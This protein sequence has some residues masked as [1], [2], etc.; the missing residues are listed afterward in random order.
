QDDRRQQAENQAKERAAEHEK[1]VAEFQQ[2]QSALEEDRK[3]LSQK[4]ALLQDDLNKLRAAKQEQAEEIKQMEAAVASQGNALA[5]Q[6][7]KLRQLVAE[8]QSL[9]AQINTMR[10]SEQDLLKRV[11][12]ADNDCHSLKQHIE[13]LSAKAT[14][15]AEEE[16]QLRMRLVNFEAAEEDQR[17]EEH[18]SELQSRSDLVCRLLLE[19][20]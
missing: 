13:A 17:S 10:Q 15:Y 1:R 9:I 3:Q 7:A 11:A 4:E 18:T 14:A 6:A 19:K 20:K 12:D 2:L 16:N 8:E 5:E